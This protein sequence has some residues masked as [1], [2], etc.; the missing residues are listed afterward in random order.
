MRGVLRFVQVGAWAGVL[1]CVCA[2]VTTFFVEV[3]WTPT[4]TKE[5]YLRRGHVGLVSIGLPF[6]HPGFVVRP[7]DANPMSP[8]S[9][10]A[11]GRLP[12]KYEREV[13]PGANQLSSWLLV[14]DLW[15]IA[16]FFLVIALIAR[17]LAAGRRWIVGRCGQC[18][19][20]L[21]ASGDVCPECG[22]RSPRKVD[23]GNE[24]PAAS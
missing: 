11:D 14:V 6:L 17:R 23:E 1:L 13:V 22:A 24:T 3:V 19:Y 8:F 21:R 2:F 9:D 5:V 20:D 10:I 16:V 4:S 7:T 18:G 12:V 15:L